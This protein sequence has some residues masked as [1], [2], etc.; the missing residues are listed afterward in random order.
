MKT[1]IVERDREVLDAGFYYSR[2]SFHDLF[3]SRFVV[4]L[5]STWRFFFP[6]IDACAKWRIIETRPRCAPTNS[7]T[8][9]SS[10]PGN[11]KYCIALE[12]AS[13][14]EGIPD[15]RRT[16]THTPVRRTLLK[17]ERDREKKKRR[18]K[19]WMSIRT[20]KRYWIY[21]VDSGSPL[22]SLRPF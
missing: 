22:P 19:H 14:N 3:Y 20:G 10:L 5:T 15:T 13:P 21:I 17:R 4:L 2:N 9:I 16:C 7:S 6:R 12:D 1:F 11:D 8:G 18:R